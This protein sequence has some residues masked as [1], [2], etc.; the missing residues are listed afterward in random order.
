MYSFYCVLG[1]YITSISDSCFHSYFFKRWFNW[2]LYQ[3]VIAA[4]PTTPKPHGMEEKS[5]IELMILEVGNLGWVQL[6]RSFGFCWAPSGLC[7]QLQVCEVVRSLGTARLSAGARSFSSMGSIIPHQACQA[8][9]LAEPG[10]REI[11]QK[12]AKPLEAPWDRHNI[13]SAAFYWF[14]Q[15]M[16]PVSPSEW[17]ELQSHIAR[18]VNVECGEELG[19]PCSRSA[20][21]VGLKKSTGSRRPQ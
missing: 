1:K 16:R 14:K 17:E 15:V 11:Q 10:V 4:K 7:G 8:F 6:G 20:T 19:K 2:R 21:Q 18:G 13:T 5:L 3:F 12:H 9:P